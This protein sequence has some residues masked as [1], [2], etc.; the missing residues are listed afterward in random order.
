MIL[1]L[2]E[3]NFIFSGR[4]NQLAAASVNERHQFL[5]TNEQ[6]RNIISQVSLSDFITDKRQ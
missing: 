3:L 1:L 2:L 5:C 4:K 6:L